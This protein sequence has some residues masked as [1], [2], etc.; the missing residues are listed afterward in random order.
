[1]YGEA[2]GLFMEKLRFDKDNVHCTASDKKKCKGVYEIDLSSIKDLDQDWAAY[3]EKFIRKMKGSDK[4]FFLYHATRGCHF[5][6]YPND[7]H[8]GISPARM[9][10]RSRIYT[11]NQYFS[12]VRVDEFKYNFTVELEQGVF[13]RGYTGGFSGAMVTDTGGVLVT[14]LYTNPQEDVSVGI[15]HIPMTIPV[16]GE[17]ARYRKVLEKYPPQIKI[18]FGGN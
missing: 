18:G 7:E 3:S 14:D 2:G 12:P 13:V 9:V 5:D 11:M 4:P 1:M 10:R 17:V 6:N 16:F 15:R 8:A